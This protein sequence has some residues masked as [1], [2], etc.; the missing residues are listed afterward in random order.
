[1]RVY[2]Q[3][4]TLDML[5][6]GR[7][8]LMAG[9]GSFIESFPLFGFDLDDHDRLFAERLD[10][11]LKIRAEEKVSWSGT[12]RAP[13]V[14]AGVYPRDERELPVWIAVGGTPQS[15]T[16]AGT[17]GIPLA[18][19]IIGGEPARFKPHADLYREAGRR[20]GI[21]ESRLKFSLNMHGFI[22]E[23]SQQAR[24][25]FYPGYADVMSRIGR[26]RGWPPLTRSQFEIACG[27][28]GNL[29]VGSPDEVAGKIKM[30][31]RLFRPD[32]LL[33]QMALGSV[34]HEAVL[35][36]MRLLGTAVASRLLPAAAWSSKKPKLS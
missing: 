11:L 30:L 33:V 23:T 4:S 18:L 22:A 8:E 14:D 5:S 26:E 17:L 9:R 27:R 19:A 10:L 36:S 3:F 12:L 20:A 32:R 31:R 28:D 34:P 2:Q 1:V 24:D 7:A 21:N 6:G 25:I 16:R 29:L 13:L 35:K 15:I